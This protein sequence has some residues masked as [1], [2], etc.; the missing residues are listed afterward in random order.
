MRSHIC[1]LAPTELEQF[2]FNVTSSL[3]ATGGKSV[4]QVLSG[5]HICVQLSSTCPFG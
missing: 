1:E 5:F 4:Y 3:F 2:E